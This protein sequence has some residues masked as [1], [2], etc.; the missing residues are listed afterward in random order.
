M[1]FLVALSQ[2]YIKC[3]H[4]IFSFPLNKSACLLIYAN[5]KHLWLSTVPK[6]VDQLGFHDIILCLPT[7]GNT[8]P[9]PG[10][11]NFLLEPNI[12]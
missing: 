4:Y 2:S 5:A 10:P 1:L 7:G 11:G 8:L 9:S 12:P 3:D 6:N